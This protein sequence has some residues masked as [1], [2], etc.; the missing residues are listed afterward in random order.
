MEA[1][2]YVNCSFF[3]CNFFLLQSL[4]IKTLDPDPDR[5]QMNTDPK[6]C[7]WGYCTVL[8]ITDK[9]IGL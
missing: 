1:Y 2:G 9:C 5:Y 8:S 7:R 6:P 3:S 4:G